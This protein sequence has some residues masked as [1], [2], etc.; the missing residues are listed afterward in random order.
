MDLEFN[1]TV[2]DFLCLWRVTP[3]GFKCTWDTKLVSSKLDY[4]CTKFEM[5][6]FHASFGERIDS[7]IFTTCQWSCGKVMFSFAPVILFRRF[8]C[9]HYPWCIGPYNTG[10]PLH[11]S[12]FTPD[13]RP[14]CWGTPCMFQPHPCGHATPLYM[15][16]PPLTPPSPQIWDLTVQG[17][18]TAL[19]LL[20][21]LGMGPHH[22]G[23]I[24]K[25]PF[26]GP[27]PRHYWTHCTGTLPSPGHVP[28]CSLWSM[29]GWKSSWSHPTVMR[30]C[31]TI[32]FSILRPSANYGRYCNLHETLE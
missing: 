27:S 5:I 24:P 4:V 12:C 3:H 23:I 32:F 9:D 2:G 7:E 21:P 25:L 16:Q 8:P 13:V 31:C 14:H 26:Q 20:S 11:Q 28:T 19:L 17:S 29:Y 18:S 10:I 1:C 15:D 30:S 22:T 6:H